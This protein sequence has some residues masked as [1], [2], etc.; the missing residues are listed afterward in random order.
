[1]QTHGTGVTSIP[2]NSVLPVG[3]PVA[4]LTAKTG[5]ANTALSAV[6]MKST[7]GMVGTNCQKTENI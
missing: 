2:M 7:T 4:G 6:P 3:G 5:V 1:M